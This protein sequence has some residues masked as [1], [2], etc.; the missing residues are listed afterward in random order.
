MTV[1]TL[2]L[3]KEL[4]HLY[5]PPAG[6]VTEVTVPPLN[7]LMLDGSGDPNHS[8]HYRQVVETLYGLAYA[9][10]FMSKQNEPFID[11]T[12]MPLE[13][14]WSFEGQ[15]QFNPAA[16]VLD[17]SKFDWTMMILQPEHIT[18][19]MVEKAVESVRKKKNPPLLAKVR[20]ERYDEG[21]AAQMMHI[22]PYSAEAPT[23]DRLHRHIL[24]SGY[25][26][27]ARHHEIYL[28]DPRKSAPEKLKTVIRQPFL[29]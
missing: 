26:F 24:D 12:V 5:H 6:K 4:K 28:G 23:V 9:L 22:G 17:K 20:F 7:Y 10:K 13:G 27:G 14:L 18:A 2:D 21:S 8:E 1:K 19:A 11:Y 29:R 16:D 3:K 25:R 15:E